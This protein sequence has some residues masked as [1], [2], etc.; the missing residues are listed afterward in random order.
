MYNVIVYYFN[1]LYP[2]GKKIKGLSNVVK[3]LLCEDHPINVVFFLLITG[4]P[5]NKILY[6]NREK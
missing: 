6:K 3:K 2:L 5:V 1:T 4:L